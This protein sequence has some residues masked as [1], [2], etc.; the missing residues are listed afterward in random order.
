MAVDLFEI[1][2]EQ[3]SLYNPFVLYRKP[4]SRQLRLLIQSGSGLNSIRS[5]NESGFVMAPFDP[6]RSPIY[7]KPDRIFLADNYVPK[8]SYRREISIVDDN[9]EARNKHISLVSKVLEEINSGPLNK[10]VVSRKIEIPLTTNPLDGFNNLLIEHPEAFCYF[11]YHPI[12][13]IWTGATP[14]LFLSKK[15]DQISTYSLAGTKA[16]ENDIP[17]NWSDKE[18][19]E[20]RYVTDFIVEQLSL[21]GLEP[22]PSATI[23]IRAGQ[24]WHLRT[25]IKAELVGQNIEGIIS[26]LHPSPAVCGSPKDKAGTFLIKCEDYD[27]EFYSGYLGEFNLTE[28]GEFDLFVNLRCMA[29]SNGLAKVYVGGGITSRSIPEDE[30]LET[31]YKSKTIIN[32]LFNYQE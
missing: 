10:V 24:L 1:A 11:W 18:K 26:K 17:P 28:S 6:D 8:P 5:Y 27:R 14:E 23:A 12:T 9:K 15:K 25:E 2:R 20:Q 31:E 19:E 3:L 4:S 13:G 21:A 30:W 32:A 7:L 16:I 29:W 22:V